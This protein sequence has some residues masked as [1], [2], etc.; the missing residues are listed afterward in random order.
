MGNNYTIL[1]TSGNKSWYQQQDQ[2]N[3][4]YAPDV[5]ITKTIGRFGTGKDFNFANPADLLE[6]SLDMGFLLPAYAVVKSCVIKCVIALVGIADIN[7]KLGNVS[8]GNQFI[9]PASVNT[10]NET[11]AQGA[12]LPVANK[13]ASKVFI[14][15]T[16]VTNTWDLATAGEWLL[17]IVYEDFGKL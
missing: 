10:L 4:E 9:T 6:Q 5:I 2:I 7:M 13:D 12:S 11:I 15:A 3:P 14:S 17:T 8:A 1:R 16:P